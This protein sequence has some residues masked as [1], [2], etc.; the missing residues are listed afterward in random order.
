MNLTTG[1]DRGP[2]SARP[3]KGSH[4]TLPE[5]LATV[6]VRGPDHA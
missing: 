3:T 4:V 5:D 6:I 1:A 2:D